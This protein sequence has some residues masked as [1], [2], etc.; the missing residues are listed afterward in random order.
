MSLDLLISKAT[1]SSEWIKWGRGTEGCGPG[2]Q[3]GTGVAW[4]P[5]PLFGQSTKLLQVVVILVKILCWTWGVLS[6]A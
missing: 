4:P 1:Q 6:S 3:A 2:R 5:C